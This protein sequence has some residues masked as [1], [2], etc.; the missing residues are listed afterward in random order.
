MVNKLTFK[1]RSKNNSF[2]R[3]TVFLSPVKGHFLK[4]NFHEFINETSIF[5]LPLICVFSLLC[6]SK[7]IDRNSKSLAD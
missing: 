3:I 4:G 7:K 6:F 1:S 2:V 5:I